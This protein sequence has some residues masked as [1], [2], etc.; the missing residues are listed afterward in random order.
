MRGGC[1]SSG[2]FSPGALQLPERRILYLPARGQ[3]ASAGAE[4][5]NRKSTMKFQDCIPAPSSP[6]CSAWD[7]QASPENK[8]WASRPGVWRGRDS[9]VQLE[10]AS[11]RVP[12]PPSPPHTGPLLSAPVASPSRVCLFSTGKWVRFSSGTCPAGALVY[13]PLCQLSFSI[14]FPSSLNFVEISCL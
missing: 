3:G 12:H 1:W 2:S 8:L 7:P 5:G 10:Q 4:D 11:T 9:G 13:S 14:C 6:P